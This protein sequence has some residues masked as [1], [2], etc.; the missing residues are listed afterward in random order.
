MFRPIPLTNSRH[1]INE[2][3][4]GQDYSDDLTKPPIVFASLDDWAIVIDLKS[5]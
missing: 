4:Q 5:P 3:T 1:Y 2:N